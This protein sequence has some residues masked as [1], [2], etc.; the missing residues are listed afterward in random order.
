MHDHADHDVHEDHP[1]DVH[2]DHPDDDHDDHL[3][4]AVESSLEN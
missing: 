2:E 3:A 4:G 1:D